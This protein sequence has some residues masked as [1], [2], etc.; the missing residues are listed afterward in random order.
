M[1]DR[2]LMINEKTTWSSNSSWSLTQKQTPPAHI[3]MTVS[4]VKKKQAKGKKI[5]FG[6]S[7]NRLYERQ[8]TKESDYE[9]H[10]VHRMRIFYWYQLHFQ[11]L[12]VASILMRDFDQQKLNLILII[13]QQRSNHLA[14]IL[15]GSNHPKSPSGPNS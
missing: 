6:R 9:K 11:C 5:V 1:S 13:K 2:N 15:F 10:Y 4:A 8:V 7:S 14:L 3:D 12:K